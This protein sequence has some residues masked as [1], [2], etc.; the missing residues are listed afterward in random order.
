[1]ERKIFAFLGDFYHQLSTMEQA[2]ETAVSRFTDV[3]LKCQLPTAENVSQALEQN[4]EIIII[5]AENRINP[6]DEVV[7]Y[8][9]T[10]EIDDKLEAYVASGGSLIVLHSGLASYPTDSKYRRMI[11]GEFLS[12]PSEHCKVR[13]LNQDNSLPENLGKDGYDFEVI[14]EF[15]IVDVDVEETNLFLFSECEEHGEQIASWFHD[16]GDGKVSCVVPAHNAEAFEHL[17]MQRLYRDEILWGLYR[18]GT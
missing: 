17:E 2:I 4:P 5:G 1:M 16:Y 7:Q 10:D 6:E 3:N 14:D 11:K 13:Y 8:W 15:Y 12:H 9:L 18:R